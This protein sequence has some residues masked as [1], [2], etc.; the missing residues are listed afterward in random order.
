VPKLVIDNC[1]VEVA[2]GATILD[3][4]RKLGIEVP[5]MCFS[6][7]HKPL[8][9]CM[10]CV[11]K[12][13]GSNSLVPACGA[14][15]REGMRVESDCEEVRQARKMALELL[16][17]D[18]V[19][20]C[21]GPCQVTC[22]AR[23]NI[24]LMIRQISAGKI[25]DAIATVKKDI[26]LPA[27]LG[28]ICPKPCERACRRAVFDEAVSIC[29]LKRYVADKDL[30]SGNPYLP[31]CKP[32]QGKRVAIVGAGPAGLAAAYYL[33][34]DGY[35]CTVFDEHEK[36]GGMLRYAV[37]QN[38]LSA[39][40]LEAEVALIEKLGVEFQA[41]TR[42]G[43]VLSLEELRR[44]FDAVFVAVGELKQGDA[45]WIGLEVKN[46]NIVVDSR[47][48]Q[49][50]LPGIFAG[51]DAVRKRRLTVRAVA[52]GKEAA[53]SISQYL[54]GQ[55]ITGPTELF[56]THIGKLQEGEIEKFVASAGKASRLMPLQEGSGFAD[57]QAS[58]EAG[59]CLHCDCRKAE[60]CKLRQYAKEYKAKPG[61]YK[62]ERR[63]FEQCTE[64]PEVIFEPGKCISCGLCVQISAEAGEKLGLSFVGRGFDVRVTVPFGHTIAEGLKHTAAQC[65]AAC[66]T[67]ALAFKDDNGLFNK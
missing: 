40:V 4:V 53:V 25:R 26:A 67:G 44:D 36:P 46:C 41:R 51:G 28:R 22:P 48:Y 35:D 17:S 60:D 31:V 18:H 52:D 58:E 63:V 50:S 8:T 29:L 16:L 12:V 14:V 3:A 66:P 11:V 7:G 2:E 19:G 62:S 30:Q 20:D 24:P 33:Q 47:T 13:S 6:E 38:Q 57:E 55:V 39:D 34:Q 65:V 23:M 64:H 59:R 5:T 49:T 42:I 43:E 45:A 32:R 9:S 61:R 10:L 56:N 1:E 15:V 27:V 54:S 21:M 37:P